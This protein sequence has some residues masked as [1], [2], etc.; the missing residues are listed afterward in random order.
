MFFYALRA[1]KLGPESISELSTI[2]KERA[3]RDGGVD[4]EGREASLIIKKVVPPL[5]VQVMQLGLSPCPMTR[6][7]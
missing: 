2:E 1:T 6:A 3:Q 4:V 7:Q 5:A